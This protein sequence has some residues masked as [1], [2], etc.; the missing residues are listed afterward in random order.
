MATGIP[1]ENSPLAASGCAN[2]VSTYR[3]RLGQ[4]GGGLDQFG[5]RRV[6]D[7]PECRAAERAQRSQR[8]LRPRQIGRKESCDVGLDREMLRR[9][10]VDAAAT[11]RATTITQQAWRV[12]SRLCEKPMISAWRHH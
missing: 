2:G 9:V 3:E 4:F 7:L 6:D 11:V 5:C 10:T 1:L 12:Q 8:P